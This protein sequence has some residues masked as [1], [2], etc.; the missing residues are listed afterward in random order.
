[1]K[2]LAVIFITVCC[3]AFCLLVITAIQAFFFY[4][5]TGESL[6]L[7]NYSPIAWIIQICGWVVV[8]G[9]GSWLGVTIAYE[10]IDP[11]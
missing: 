1:M 3:V 10:I 7:S 5:F 8:L 4:G 6:S 11:V 9:V 2:N